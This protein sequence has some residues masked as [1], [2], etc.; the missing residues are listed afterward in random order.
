[1]Q[2]INGTDLR[3]WSNADLSHRALNTFPV[4]SQLRLYPAAKGEYKGRFPP[5]AE[6]GLGRWHY[7][8]PGRN[9]VHR[10][11]ICQSCGMI[12]IRRKSLDK[13]G[14]DVGSSYL[15]SGVRSNYREQGSGFGTIYSH[16]KCFLKLLHVPTQV[17]DK[18]NR[19]PTTGKVE[20]MSLEEFKK[21]L[22]TNVF[23]GK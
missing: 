8:Q 22:V 10:L 11:G 1:M 17:E 20:T 16:I 7:C 21:F 12:I 14:V 15:M 4:L 2:K 5:D 19:I 6:M 13:E 23:T 9:P 18:Y 3:V